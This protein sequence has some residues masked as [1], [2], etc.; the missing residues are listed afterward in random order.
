MN[1]KDTLDIG[2]KIV[3]TVVGAAWV[4]TNYVRGRTHKPRLRLRVSADRI[5]RDGGEYLIVKAE[6]E[7]VGLARVEV[8]HQGCHVTIFVDDI[9]RPAPFLWG[10]GWKRVDESLPLL[11][12]QKEDRFALLEDQ[13]FV[14]PSSLVN[15]Q[16]LIA[17]P[18][19]TER[20]IRVLAH[21][22]SEEVGWTAIAVLSPQDAALRHQSAEMELA[23]RRSS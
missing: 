14:E 18:N 22:E 9:P 6:L 7:N 21:A 20:F 19:V 2:V 12:G 23:A 16:I 5:S 15:D 11:N 10:S 8:K 13:N 17:V 3:A 4:F 1:W